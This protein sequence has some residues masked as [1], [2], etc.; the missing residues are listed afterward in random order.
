MRKLLSHS[1][2]HYITTKYRV[3]LN[4]QTPRSSSNPQKPTRHYET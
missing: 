2:N 4:S 3:A 1:E